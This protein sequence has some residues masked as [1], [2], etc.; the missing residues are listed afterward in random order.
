[1]F[2]GAL[3]IFVG[4]NRSPI[5]KGFDIFRGK[6]KGASVREKAKAILELLNDNDMLR[7]EREKAASRLNVLAFWMS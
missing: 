6:D 1:M 3:F 4:K 5:S 7:S 2:L